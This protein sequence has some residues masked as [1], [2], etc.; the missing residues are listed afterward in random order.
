MLIA[1]AILLV[2]W[3]ATEWDGLGLSALYLLWLANS[4]IVTRMRD[5]NAHGK[6]GCLK[7]VF[8]WTDSHRGRLGIGLTAGGLI[9]V[10]A[11][12]LLIGRGSSAFLLIG[13]GCAGHGSAGGST[14][15]DKP[16]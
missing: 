10:I 1:S 16:P 3:L 12:L 9:L 8:T 4:A 5:I 15:R 6:D 11:G 13:G 14:Y 7:R 2:L